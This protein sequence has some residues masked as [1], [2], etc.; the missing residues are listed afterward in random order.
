MNKSCYQLIIA[1]LLLSVPVLAQSPSGGPKFPPLT[2]EQLR[3]FTGLNKPIPSKEM[4][5]RLR[6]QASQMSESQ[7]TTVTIVNSA[8]LLPCGL[9]TNPNKCTNGMFLTVICFAECHDFDRNISLPLATD[10][11]RRLPASLRIVRGSSQ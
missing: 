6:A 3:I 8:S 5:A 9:S 7:T 11:G 4:E 1:L 10:A 2:A